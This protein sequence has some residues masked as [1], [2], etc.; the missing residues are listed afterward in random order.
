M[1][2]SAPEEERDPIL[3]IFLATSAHTARWS[4]PGALFVLYR[5]E[6]SLEHRPPLCGGCMSLKLLPRARQL[7][8]GPVK[9]EAQ[10]GSAAKAAFSLERSCPTKSMA[11]VLAIV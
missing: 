9:S 2:W 10:P 3:P 1:S 8:C 6:V 5:A 7:W 11:P 4:E